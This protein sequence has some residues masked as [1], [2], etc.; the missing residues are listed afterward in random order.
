MAKKQGKII[1]TP[2]KEV[3]KGM[4]VTRDN[5]QI[6]IIT[7]TSESHKGWV[8]GNCIK[9]PKNIGLRISTLRTLAVEYQRAMSGQNC[10]LGLADD[11]TETIRLPLKRSQWQPAID[12]R[13][14]DN[15]KVVDFEIIELYPDY[16]SKLLRLN[17]FDAAKIIPK[18]KMGMYRKNPIIRIGKFEI[19]MMTDTEG[20]EKVW[21]EDTKTGEGAEMSGKALEPYLEEGYNKLF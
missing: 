2:V 13:E 19:S 4:Q 21:I 6:Y 1:S 20:E 18:K 10:P 5:V 14:I 15:G 16:E 12:N 3:T 7:D 9:G 8:V 11:G 17:A